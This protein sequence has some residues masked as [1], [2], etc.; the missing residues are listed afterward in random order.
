MCKNGSE[1]HGDL[2]NLLPFANSFLDFALPDDIWSL[3]NITILGQLFTQEK[4]LFAQLQSCFSWSL[5]IE[6]NSRISSKT[7]QEF[8][9]LTSLVIFTALGVNSY[10]FF[11]VMA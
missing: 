1:T 6:R 8:D 3:L 2:F 4:E 11:V 9:S 7:T 10:H 5:W